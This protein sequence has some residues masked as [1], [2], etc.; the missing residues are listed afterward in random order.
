MS[1]TTEGKQA[2]K[3]SSGDFNVG[4]LSSYLDN[5][6]DGLLKYLKAEGIE[7]LSL[8]CNSHEE[9]TAHSWTYDT[10]LCNPEELR[11]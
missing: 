10:V 5:D 4:D 7:E 9:R 6:I 3:Y 11:E 1:E 2:W 8:E